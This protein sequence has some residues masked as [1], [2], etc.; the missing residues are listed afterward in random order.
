MPTYEFSHDVEGCKH[1]WEIWQSM[2][3]PN[4]THCPKCNCEGNIKKLISLGGRGIVELYGQELVEKIQADA[5]QIQRDA[6][7]DEK[8]YSN[9]LGADR[10]HQLQTRI[11]Q[12][13][14]R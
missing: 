6:A 8:V 7:K 9:L 11:D 14:R 3:A 13:K 1:E 5:K 4:P 12:Q 2:S 10:Y